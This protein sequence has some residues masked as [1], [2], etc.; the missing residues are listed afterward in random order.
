MKFGRAFGSLRGRVATVAT[1]AFAAVLLLVG[2]ASLA[3][4]ADRERQRVDDSLESRP[5]R[6]LAR[7]LGAPVGPPSSGPGV[8]ETRSGPDD[9]DTDAFGPP[10]LRPQGEYVR[11]TIGGETVRGVDVPDGLPSPDGPGLRT[12]EAD[13]VEYRSL[14]RTIG[15]DS[16]IETGVDLSDASA[17]INELRDRLLLV[18]LAGL[19]LVAALIWWLAGLALKP[20]DRLSRA[21]GEVGGTEDLSRRI[22]PGTGAAEVETL[23]A[24]INSMLARLEGSARETAA[25]LEA[26]RRFAGDAG[27][28]LRTPMTSLQANLG[29]IRRNPDLEEAE[30]KAALDQMERDSARMMRMLGTLQTLARGDSAAALPEERVELTGLVGSAVEAARRRHAE[31]EW[32][33]KA[34]L[35]EIELA[36]WSDGLA[37]MLDNLLENAARHGKSGGTVAT[38]LESSDHGIVITVDDDGPGIGPEE[39]E[40]VFE[41][42][43]RGDSSVGTG[44]GLSLVRQQAR[45]HGGDAL[46]EASPAGGARF[47]VKLDADPD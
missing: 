8:P 29:A 24:S 6:E 27:H 30:L 37:S 15:P 17:R 32:S 40:K 19:L 45:L 4:F 14:A 16:L 44:L 33:L 10:V 39:R 1:L 18:G 28:E 41:R 31:I 25:A 34:P 5:Q 11:L 21:A 36:G 35:D 47:R 42:F 20:L 12:L 43:E 13:G 38:T 3:S 23:T 7:A 46:V 9:R 2:V 26:T 22:N